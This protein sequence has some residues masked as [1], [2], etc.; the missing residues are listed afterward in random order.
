MTG[1]SRAKYRE[2]AKGFYGRAKKC[3]RVMATR[4][5]KALIYSYRDRKA[6]RRTF[7][8][9]WIQ[10]INAATREHSTPYNKFLCALA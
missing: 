10:T 5:D 4:V 8:K 3:I 6:R 2:L 7:R 9:E 1:F